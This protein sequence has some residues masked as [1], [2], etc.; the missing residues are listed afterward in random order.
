[1]DRTTQD[2]RPASDD[3]V[4]EELAEAFPDAGTAEAARELAEAERAVA[5]NV[6]TPRQRDGVT[7][8]RDLRRTEDRVDAWRAAT[9]TGD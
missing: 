2:D 1:M 5:L 4:I 6:A 3:R 7:A 9:A 8:T